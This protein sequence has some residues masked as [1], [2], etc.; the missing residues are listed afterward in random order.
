MV[1]IKQLIKILKG[2]ER[3][4]YNI[5]DH[6]QGVNVHLP[7]TIGGERSPTRI[8]TGGECSPPK[9]VKVYK[10]GVNVHLPGPLFND[11]KYLETG[12]RSPPSN[13]LIS[14]YSSDFF[15]DFKYLE[16]GERS[17]PS[18][19]LISLYSSDFFN[20][21]KYLETGE[22]SPTRILTGGERSPTRILTGGERSP[23]IKNGLN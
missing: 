16:T 1:N 2:G 13:I 10:K 11:F 12:E 7:R 9:Q 17:P 8:L 18:N 6:L 15:N 4:P 21:F 23:P 3:S 19:I 20:D 5:I 22:R 14:L